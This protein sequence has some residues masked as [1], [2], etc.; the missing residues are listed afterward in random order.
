MTEKKIPSGWKFEKIDGEESRRGFPEENSSAKLFWSSRFTSWK[1]RSTYC[2]VWRVIIP[3]LK[4]QG[5][6]AFV[7]QKQGCWMHAPKTIQVSWHFKICS[8]ISKV[9]S[10][11]LSCRLFFTSQRQRSTDVG[12]P[13]TMCSGGNT[14]R[15]DHSSQLDDHRKGVEKSRCEHAKTLD[16]Q[17][18]M[19]VVNITDDRQDSADRDLADCH[20]HA[21]LFFWLGSWNAQEL[22]TLKLLH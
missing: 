7:V 8:G 16:A 19:G 1:C 14:P 20:N 18:P 6:V 4:P 11:S 21:P 3:L 13:R 9:V 10:L 22:S 17:S 12:T 5:Y 15:D 2:S